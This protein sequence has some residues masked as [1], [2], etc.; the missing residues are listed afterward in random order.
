MTQTQPGSRT[1]TELYDVADIQADRPTVIVTGSA[2]LLGW[3]VCKRL[4]DAGYFVFGF[5]RAGTGEP[6]K[7]PY[8]RDVEF[9]V[10][11][12]ANVR[13]AMEDVRKSRGNRLASVVHLAAYYDFSGEDSPLYKKVTIEGTDRLLNHLQS[14]QVEQFIFSSTML[15]HKNVSPG[16]YINEDSPLEGDWA[17]PKSKIETEKLIVDGHP[18]V[19][20]VLLR[21]A[22]VYDDW[23]QQPTLVQQIKRI[24]EKDLQSHLFPGD[25]R[26]GQ[27]AVHL[28]D[29]VD[30]VI[31][32][33]ENRSTIPAKT[34]ILIGEADPPSYETLQNRIAELLHG[35]EWKTLN[36]PQWFAEAGAH[37]LD[38]TVGGFI[39][40]FMIEMADDHYALD[41]SRAKELLGWEPKHNLLK[42]LDV[43]CG[44]LRKDPDR[45]YKENGLK[46]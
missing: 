38:K 19:R 44:N 2:G 1:D 11:D 8:V 30:S 23:G 13:W 4:S 45:W 36:I 20:S 6:P 10:T 35:E 5:D 34:P 42:H 27:S 41:I 25:L 40:P 28:E 46:R 43:I 17:Y 32:A 26:A 22:G 16:E 14:F 31:Q 33:V 37:V 39:K 12:Y 24:Y 29:A 9:D 15:V 21:I 3:H 18:Q 7:G